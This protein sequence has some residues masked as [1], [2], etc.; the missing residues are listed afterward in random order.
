LTAA[1]PSLQFEPGPNFHI[2]LYHS[3]EPMTDLAEESVRRNG[4][5]YTP[6][7][8]RI[9]AVPGVMGIIGRPYLCYL[10]KSPMFSWDEVHFE[11]E[12][13]FGAK[14]VPMFPDPKESNEKPN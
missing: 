11:M 5:A 13:L 6:L 7:F 1:L 4:R 12:A 14:I 3:R 9:L 8:N 2:R 10:E